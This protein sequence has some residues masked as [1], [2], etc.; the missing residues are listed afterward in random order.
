MDTLKL[1]QIL[2]DNNL[3]KSENGKNVI[4]KCVYCGDH[5]TVSKQGHLYVSLNPEMPTVHCFYCNH[6]ATIN[7]LIKV[8]TGSKKLAEEVLPKEELL[9]LRNKN[10]TIKV[11]KKT[12]TFNLSKKETTSFIAKRNYM[13]TRTFHKLNIDDIPNLIFDFE[14]F[15]KQNN[16]S[17]TGPNGFLTDW[18]VDIIKTQFVGFL[19]RHHTLIFA[20][21]ITNSEY[22][23][24]KMNLQS[25]SNGLLDYWYINGGDPLSDTVVLAE[26]NFDVLGEYA[27]DS[28]KLKGKVRLYAAGNSFSYSS[29][30]KSVCFDEN[31][32]KCDVVILSD[33]DKKP[34]FY[35]KFKRDNSHIIKSLKIWYNTKGNDFGEFPILPRLHKDN[36]SKYKNKYK[37]KWF[38]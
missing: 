17:A 14:T 30:L 5:K 20:R 12:S 26:G 3:Y 4:A 19:S 32:F 23:F 7:D 31:L 8:I 2:K 36:E 21:N 18:E 11:K 16:I 29:L 35:N 6:S 28:L 9:K 15:F 10:K 33:N 1:R 37:N 25:T 24:K 13:I 22:G 27:I 38:K 34:E